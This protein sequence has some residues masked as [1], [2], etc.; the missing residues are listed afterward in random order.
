MK[1]S[2]ERQRLPLPVCVGGGGGDESLLARKCNT[3][4]AI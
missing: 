4:S 3:T 1:E 2:I